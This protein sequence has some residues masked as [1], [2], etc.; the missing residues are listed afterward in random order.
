MV[1]RCA[2][3]SAYVDPASLPRRTPGTIKIL[4][5]R[6]PVHACIQPIESQENCLMQG[7]R[8]ARCRLVWFVTRHAGAR[9]WAREE[10][11]FADMWVDHLDPQDVARG[12]RVMGSLPTH[13]AA[14]VCRKGAYYFHLT[15][16]V[17]R[18]RRGVELDAGE[19]RAAGARLEPMHVSRKRAK[20]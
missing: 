2:R 10:G 8:C 18:G 17:Q 9:A 12:D 5:V 14:E 20:A 3:M 13:V 11:I 7:R 19:L 16:S 1:G 15:V 4:F 6:L